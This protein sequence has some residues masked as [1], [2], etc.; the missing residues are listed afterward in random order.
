MWVGWRGGG[1]GGEEGEVGDYIA[2][3]LAEC[4][5]HGLCKCVSMADGKPN[6]M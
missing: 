1:W 5:R 3:V 4:R 6:K 2:P